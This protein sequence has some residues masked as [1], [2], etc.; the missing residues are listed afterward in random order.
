MLTFHAEFSECFVCHQ[1]LAHDLA[2][3]NSIDCF[4]QDIDV[5]LFSF[6]PNVVVHK[7]T[8]KLHFLMK[9]D[10]E[11]NGKTLSCQTSLQVTYVNH[12]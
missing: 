11:R 12:Q 5:A 6:L 8:V 4:M 3:D 1:N 10:D 9:D 2:P 7:P